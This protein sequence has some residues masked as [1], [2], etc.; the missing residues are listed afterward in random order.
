ME[1]ATRS[2]HPTDVPPWFF[3]ILAA[4][5]AVSISPFVHEYLLTRFLKDDICLKKSQTPA[6]QNAP[7]TVPRRWFDVPGSY[8]HAGRELKLEFCIMHETDETA[9]TPAG[10][11]GLAARLQD[12]GEASGDRRESEASSDLDRPRL[13]VLD[14]GMRFVPGHHLAYNLGLQAECKRR[15]LP[16]EFYVHAEC[17]PEVVD[18]LHA[19]PVLMPSQYNAHSRDKYCA[20]LEDFNI[21]SKMVEYNLYKNVTGNIE[22]SDIVFVH[23]ADPR[24]V[25]GIA[26]WYVSLPNDERPYLCL[27]F[28][29]HGYR[30]VVI[31]YKVLV[32]SIF[33]LALKPFMTMEKVHL[34]ASNNLI[35]AQI[36][37]IAE[38]P[39]PVFPVPLGLAEPPKEYRSRSAKKTLRIGFAGE[40]RPEQGVDLLPDI[41]GEILATNQDVTFTVQFGCHFAE[42]TTR[43]RLGAF[44]EKVLFLEECF[45]GEAFH[46]LIGSFDALLLPYEA[47]QYIERSSQIVIEAIALGVPLIVPARTSLALEVKR[48]GCGHVLI[49][50]HEAPSIVAAV[51]RFLDD[52]D[53]LARKSARA[54]PRCAAF[55]CG[56]TLVDLLL[57]IRDA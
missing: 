9:Q 13:V 4:P 12:G 55:H 6:Q 5:E 10:T 46:R 37:V 8:G 25:M 2:G 30:Y 23:T 3:Q 45:V 39:C 54:A 32:R 19:K 43:N 15:R 34:A 1:D 18:A 33:R 40:G 48:F 44:G 56:K 35:A 14:H 26:A 22:S 53:E 36:K 57:G 20:Y 50:R 31:E 24:I 49:E 28:Q 7:A 29:N 21:V 41:I 16:V 17:R 47:C 11:V 51:Q 27:K 52:H 42:E 38:K